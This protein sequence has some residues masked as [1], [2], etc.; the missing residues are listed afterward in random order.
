MPFALKSE[1]VSVTASS[2]SLMRAFLSTDFLS[3]TA[4]I[5]V[6]ASTIYF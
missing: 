5:P 6:H 4:K 1:E 3:H 2:Y